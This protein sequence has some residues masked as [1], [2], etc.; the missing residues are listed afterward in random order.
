MKMI[1]KIAKKFYSKAKAS[2]RLTHKALGITYVATKRLPLSC[3]K[4]MP[5][6]EQVR[7][8]RINETTL[9]KIIRSIKDYLNYE[10][11]R[12]VVKRVKKRNGKYE[13]VLFDGHHRFT[14]FSQLGY[15]DI[16]VDVIDVPEEL[17]TFS[18]KIYKCILNKDYPKAGNSLSDVIKTCKAEIKKRFPKESKVSSVN[19]KEVKKVIRDFI[20]RSEISLIKKERKIVDE[21]LFAAFSSGKDAIK[22]GDIINWFSIKGEVQDYSDPSLIQN[23]MMGRIQ[24]HPIKIGFGGLTHLGDKDCFLLNPVHIC[25]TKAHIKQNLWE[26][27][28]YMFTSRYNKDKNKIPPALFAMWVNQDCN[29]DLKIL[30]EKR[31][32]LQ[33]YFYDTREDLAEATAREYEYHNGKKLSEQERNRIKYTFKRWAGNLGCITQLDDEKT[34]VTSKG[35]DNIYPYNEDF[36]Y[37]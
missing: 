16:V 1:L 4:Q 17:D 3:I 7:A 29:G 15:T 21:A 37:A 13:Y 5:E 25:S 20:T 26:L 23:L 2:A 22:N 8:D 6:E 9:Q 36:H 28:P 19:R 34:F 24:G 11:E 31:E 18:I 35:N 30:E 12:V 14:A 33:K 27:K 32:E 10:L